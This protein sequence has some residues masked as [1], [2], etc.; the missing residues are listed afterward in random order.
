MRKI[1]PVGNEI[2]R[3]MPF[4]LHVIWP[5]LLTDCTQTYIL[6]IWRKRQEVSIKFLVWAEIRTKMYFGLQIKCPSCQPISTFEQGTISNN[7]LSTIQYIDLSF[8]LCDSFRKQFFWVVMQSV[9]VICSWC[10]QEMYHLHIQGWVV[11]QTYCVTRRDSEDLRTRWDNG[12]VI[13]QEYKCQQETGSHYSTENIIG[14]HMNCCLH[15]NIQGILS[16][17]R[18]HS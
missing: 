12:E 15:C 11:S 16:F 5:S 18:H 17:N 10:Y 3:K 1:P 9:W 13:H 6:Y 7:I 4:V 2:Q 8:P 14:K